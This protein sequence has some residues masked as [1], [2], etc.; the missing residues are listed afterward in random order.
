MNPREG[1]LCVGGG[2]REGDSFLYQLQNQPGFGISN[3]KNAFLV[4]PPGH[5]HLEKGINVAGSGSCI[6]LFI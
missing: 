3:C 4:F 5:R 2:G 1:I 6:M